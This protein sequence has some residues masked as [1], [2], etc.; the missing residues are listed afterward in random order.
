MS[1]SVIPFPS[2]KHDQ[3][4]TEEEWREFMIDLHE[5][6]RDA[7]MN[8]QDHDMLITVTLDIDEVMELC[9][10]IENAVP[11]GFQEE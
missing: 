8:D 3:P 1:G 11:S 2:P 5:R 4:W 6:L 7:L 9:Q 10:L